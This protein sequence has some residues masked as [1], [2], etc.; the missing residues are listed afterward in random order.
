MIECNWELLRLHNVS[1]RCPNLTAGQDGCCLPLW[2]FCSS[3]GRWTLV[4]APSVNKCASPNAVSAMVSQQVT[5]VSFPN[6][7]CVHCAGDQWLVSGALQSARQ[8]V[9]NP[10]RRGKAKGYFGHPYVGQGIKVSVKWTVVM[11]LWLLCGL[12]GFAKVLA[13]LAFKHLSFLASSR[14][15]RFW[16][17]YLY[18][19]LGVCQY[20]LILY[21]HKVKEYL[22][23]KK[24]LIAVS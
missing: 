24:T 4:R 22:F 21:S 18:F 17:S 19:S 20:I 12:E 10:H 7:P 16:S 1:Y 8:H 13:A 15:L 3:R 9:W 14:N 5:F 6:S 2:F 23:V 11:G